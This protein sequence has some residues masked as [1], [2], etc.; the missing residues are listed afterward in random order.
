MISN[1]GIYAL[2]LKDIPSLQHCRRR[3]DLIYLYQILKGTYDIHNQ[4]FTPSNSITT[5]GHTKKLLI[6]S[7]IQIHMQDLISIATE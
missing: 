5:R 4:L 7:I 3:G 2:H 1:V 6:L